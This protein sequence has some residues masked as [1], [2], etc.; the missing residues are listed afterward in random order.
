MND[1]LQQVEL[2]DGQFYVSQTDN[3]EPTQR[4][5]ATLSKQIIGGPFA[6]RDAGNQFVS[7]QTQQPTSYHVWQHNEELASQA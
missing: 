6:N 7:Q 2:I 4:S 3:N 1:Q 5:F